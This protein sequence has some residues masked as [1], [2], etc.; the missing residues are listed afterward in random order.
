[1]LDAVDAAMQLA[2]AADPEAL[3]LVASGGYQ[4]V[5]EAFARR[6]GAI[7]L[8][9]P[10]ELRDGVATGGLAGAVR[11]GRLKAEAVLR[12]AGEGQILVAF[13]DTAADV[14]VLSLAAR[15]VAV[16]PDAVLRRTALGRGWEIIEA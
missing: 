15:P 14:P 11:S 1:V 7:A 2:R 8:G 3:L 4:P 16:A 5:V 12:E 6:L 9:T 10:L 13:G